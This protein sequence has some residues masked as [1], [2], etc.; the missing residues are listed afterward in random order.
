MAD[1]KSNV[2]LYLGI[3]CLVI[4]VL[5]ALGIGG[6]VFFGVSQ[7]KQFTADMEDPVKRAEKVYEVLGTRELPPGFHP[8]FAM[9]A[10][11]DVFQVAILLDHP[12]RTPD[13][14]GNLGSKGFIF[15]QVL[16]MNA[17][18]QQRLR[19]FFEGKT[20]DPSV[21][22]E[23]DINVEIEDQI[24]RGTF[25]SKSSEVLFVSSRG[26]VTDIQM[27]GGTKVDVGTGGP[28][29]GLVTAMIYECP[30]DAR[31]RF[32][33]LYG[34]DPE[35]DA[36]TSEVDLSGTVA[37]RAEVESFMSYLDICG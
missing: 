29:Q 33:I 32:G 13:E 20:N 25:M 35:P 23:Y 5:G 8:G 7:F 18:D 3:G 16:S 30:D 22:R 37:D 2:W 31:K 9:S 28:M 27:Q 36:Q 12:V 6:C 19:D 14:I 11:F 4:V 34:P 17:G 1:G 21:L 15:L 26:K 10:P 24:D